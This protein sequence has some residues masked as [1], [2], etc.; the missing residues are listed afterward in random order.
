MGTGTILNDIIQ[1]VPPNPHSLEVALSAMPVGVS[2]ANLSDQKIVFMN[3]KFTEIFGYQVGDF[4][5]IPDWIQTTYPFHEDRTL[6]WEKWGAYFAAPDRFE[7]PIDPMELRIRCK[8]GTVK[9]VIHSGV[10]LPEAGWALATFVDITDRKRDELLIQAAELQARENQAIYQTLLDHSPGMIILSPFD[11]SRR[12]ISSAVTQI[13]GF[14]PDEYLALEH[15]EMLHPEDRDKAKHVVESVKHGKASQILR[16]RALQKDGSYRWVEAIITGYIDPVSEQIAGYVATVVDISEQKKREDLLATEHRELSKAASLDELTGIANRRTFNQTFKREAL[17][18][19]RSARDLSL[20]MI[21]VDHFKQFNDLYGHLAG[22]DCLKN[23]AEAIKQALR[24]DIDLVARFG[25]EEFVALMPLTDAAG[26]ETV[27]RGI[28]KAISG[29]GI[30]HA[31]SPY[32]VVTVSIG[33]ACRTADLLVNPTLLIEQADHALYQ[34]KNQGRNSYHL[35]DRE[36]SL[37]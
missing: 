33:V 7:L 9:T 34:A 13:T 32:G 16:Y 17:R 10:V 25:G 18:Q 14:T 22:D 6:A 3:R 15:L 12:Y 29:L 19:A 8:D 31:G 28:L 36:D 27:A 2:W 37:P 21:D 20:L 11:R 4:V 5:D 30:P 35:V 23:I 24:R 26:A 1:N